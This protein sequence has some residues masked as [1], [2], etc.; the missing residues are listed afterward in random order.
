MGETGFVSR[1]S[2]SD[3]R[4]ERRKLIL[5]KPSTTAALI[6][7]MPNTFHESC[8]NSKFSL[9]P[10]PLIRDRDESTLKVTRINLNRSRITSRMKKTGARLRFPGV[11][12]VKPHSRHKRVHIVLLVRLRYFK[13]SFLAT[14]I[15]PCAKLRR[16]ENSQQGPRR[17]H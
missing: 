17:E 5:R 9:P 1:T 15:W 14:A 12:T 13:V 2:T 4:I 3:I 10:V 16:L 6:S 11:R 7:T 8:P